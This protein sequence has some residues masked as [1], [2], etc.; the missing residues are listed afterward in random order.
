[1]KTL[2]FFT[3]IGTVLLASSCISINGGENGNGNVVTEER[4]LTDD[5]TEVRGSAGLDVYLT[6]G[7]ENKIVVE[8]DEN[9]LQYI[10]T[11]IENG[12][13]HVTTSEN[14]GRSK[15]KKVYVTYKNLT[16]IEASSGADVTG[17][18]VIKS[19]NL[20]L[21]SSSGADLKVEVFTQQLSAKSSSGSD[22]EIS[23]KA[24]S[25][26]ADASSGS[27]I[28]AKKLL[29]I[30]CIAEASSGAEVTVNVQEKLETK[31]G[32]GGEINYYGNPVS[33]NSN[34]SHSGSVNKM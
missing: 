8:A 4:N 9:L 12:K 16:N 3:A 27:E 18:S 25:L 14:I 26:D 15:A 28:N 23:G 6:Q 7:S 19:Q 17:N 29:V 5:F 10:E 22:L 21:K 20:S 32:S 1:M 33:V 11:D 30:N 13:L 24:S 34:K 31:I 2:I